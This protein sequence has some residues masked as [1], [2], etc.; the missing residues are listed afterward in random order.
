VQVGYEEVL[1]PR[2]LEIDDMTKLDRIMD[3]GCLSA[4]SWTKNMMETEAIAQEGF[5]YNGPIDERARISA[6]RLNKLQPEIAAS[7]LQRQPVC[8][9]PYAHSKRDRKDVLNPGPKPPYY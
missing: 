2:F 1:I 8:Y 3:L 4:S 6:N 5:D 9:P 7:G